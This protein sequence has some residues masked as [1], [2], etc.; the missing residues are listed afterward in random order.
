MARNAATITS[1]RNLNTQKLRV[2]DPQKLRVMD[3]QKLRVMDPQ[4]L[5]VMDPQK[6][7]V[8]DPQKLRVMDPQKLRVILLAIPKATKS[9]QNNSSTRGRPSRAKLLLLPTFSQ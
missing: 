7:R 2:V 8:M 5:R 9:N 1:S 6:L 4:K 3:P